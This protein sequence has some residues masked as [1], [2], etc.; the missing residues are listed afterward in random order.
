MFPDQSNLTRNRGKLRRN[1]HPQLYRMAQMDLAVL[2]TNKPEKTIRNAIR[3]GATLDQYVLS[4][5]LRNASAEFARISGIK[6]TEYRAFLEKELNPPESDE[7]EQVAESENRGIDVQV[8]H[9]P[10]DNDS[11]DQPEIYPQDD[12]DDIRPQDIPE[13]DSDADFWCFV[14]KYL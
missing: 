3:R 10:T 5:I 1:R 14:E 6:S 7:Q 2:L 8:N 13:S 9:Q 11:F 4:V 12:P